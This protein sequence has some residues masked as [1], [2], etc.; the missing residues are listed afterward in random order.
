[1]P[2]SIMYIILKMNWISCYIVCYLWIIFDVYLCSTNMFNLVIIAFDRM[3]AVKYA[4]KYNQIMSPTRVR[5]LIL[6]IWLLALII[7]LPLVVYIIWSQLSTTT[8][9]TTTTTTSLSS[10]STIDIINILSHNNN[11]NKQLLHSYNYYN[12]CLQYQC[13]LINVSVYIRLFITI[14]SMYLPTILMC[15]F[16]F[17]VFSKVIINKRGISLG[18]LI[19]KDS[20]YH[21]RSDKKNTSPKQSINIM[22]SNV[23]DTLAKINHTNSKRDKFVKDNQ[24]KCSFL[25]VHVG[26]KQLQ[27]GNNTTIITNYHYNSNV[28]SNNTN[29][30]NN[31][32]NKDNND[33]SQTEKSI[34][35]NKNKQYDS[36]ITT[37][38]STTDVNN[39][40]CHEEQ[41]QQQHQQQQPSSVLNQ[42]VQQSTLTI[43]VNPSNNLQKSDCISSNQKCDNSVILTQMNSMIRKKHSSSLSEVLFKVNRNKI[44][45]V[46]IQS[47]Q[48]TQLTQSKQQLKVK[49]TNILR[50]HS[51]HTLSPYTYLKPLESTQSRRSTG[52]NDKDAKF[53]DI[54]TL[55]RCALMPLH[56]STACSSISNEYIDSSRNSENFL[57]LSNTLITSINSNQME[58]LTISQDQSL[59]SVPTNHNVKV[60][61]T[62]ELKAI[63]MFLLNI[64]SMITCWLPY[65][66]L[67]LFTDNIPDLY[68]SFT[69]YDFFYWLRFLCIAFNPL[70]YGS[71]SEDLRKAFRRFI[72]HCGKVKREKKALKRLVLAGLGAAGI[73]YGH[74][75][76][77]PQMKSND[78][79][80]NNNN[81]NNKAVIFNKPLIIADT[82]EKI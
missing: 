64:S 22:N 62:I 32:N 50:K 13:S 1:M 30:N 42:Q 76:I 68:L 78:N 71:A 28:Y 36:Y 73:P 61:H 56:S 66:T 38:T 40:V 81:N 82:E 79:N 9:T 47:N 77:I 46:T 14:F 57:N 10:S 27:L 18:L 20:V 29:N 33:M 34:I 15:Y 67:L 69:V 24:S 44:D 60:K 45:D 12:K 53:N 17:H 25:R 8:T 80:N 16:Y 48:Q 3:L 6:L 39:E 21:R 52:K 55:R 59:T 23:D 63:C 74:R 37:K 35:N 19:D 75:I 4:V 31:N 5:L 54:I 49:L 41:Q 51:F 2:I 11:N 70:I 26:G 65:S 72:L 58:R 7:I 43:Q